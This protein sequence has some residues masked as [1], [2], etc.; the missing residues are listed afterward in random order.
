MNENN[1][2]HLVS[3]KE[4]EREGRNTMQKERQ[5]REKRSA[6]FFFLWVRHKRQWLPLVS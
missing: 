3:L 6:F 2:G 5:R 1:T 4:R